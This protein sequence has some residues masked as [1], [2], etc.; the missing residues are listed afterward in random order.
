MWLRRFRLTMIFW[1]LAPI[2]LWRRALRRFGR[3]RSGWI[4]PPPER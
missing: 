2:A 3:C 4:E 1:A